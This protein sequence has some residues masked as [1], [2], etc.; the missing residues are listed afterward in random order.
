MNARRAFATIGL[1]ALLVT[2]TAMCGSGGRR[3]GALLVDAGLRLMDAGRM[4]L[5]DA[6]AEPMTLDLPC[7][8]EVT[9]TQDNP[10]SRAHFALT[11][12][13]A[14]LDL[15]TLD[16]ARARHVSAIVCGREIFEARDFCV[17]GYTCSG[18]R[19]P[20]GTYDC[21]TATVELDRGRL[22]VACGQRSESTSSEPP[23]H[24]I[25]WR[26]ARV[27]ID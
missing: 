22:R 15:A 7:D 1:A 26:T 17:P 8:R 20:D 9:W 5:P 16:P 19:P 25:R 23:V 24:G 2:L 4:M 18:E 3:G 12:Y 21:Q 14:E 11:S 27:S 13:Y 10:S 6:A